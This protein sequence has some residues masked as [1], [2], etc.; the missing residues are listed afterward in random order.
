MI[1]FHLHCQLELY[2][3][4]AKCR[5]DPTLGNFSLQHCLPIYLFRLFVWEGDWL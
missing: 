2:V 1:V 4:G 5:T 3:E